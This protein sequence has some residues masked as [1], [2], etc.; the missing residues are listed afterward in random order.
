MTIS[1][2]IY[3][4]RINLKRKWWRFQ[5]VIKSLFYNDFLNW[6][7]VCDILMEPM[8]WFVENF[9]AC[10]GP[11]RDFD[12]ICVIYNFLNILNVFYLYIFFYIMQVSLYSQYIY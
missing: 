10:L 1:L 7:Y 12:H 5:I 9:T 6:G 4:L 3:V 8:F 11:V 2:F